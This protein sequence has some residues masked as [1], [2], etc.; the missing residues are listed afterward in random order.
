MIDRGQA[1]RVSPSG[2]AL[3][4]VKDAFEG[5]LMVSLPCVLPALSGTAGG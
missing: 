1:E 5:V 4:Q 2:V 3:G